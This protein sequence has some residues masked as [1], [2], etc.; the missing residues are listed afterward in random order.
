[1]PP[2]AALAI[3]AARALASNPDRFEIEKVIPFSCTPLPALP[4]AASMTE[5]AEE[6][7]WVVTDR[8]S[9]TEKPVITCLEPSFA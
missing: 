8:S 2:S 5:P 3:A 7:S 9:S 4:A 6:M 1:M